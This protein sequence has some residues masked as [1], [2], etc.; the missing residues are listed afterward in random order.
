MAAESTGKAEACRPP[1]SDSPITGGET[2]DYW[3][4]YLTLFRHDC[5]ALGEKEQW[6]A[7][8]AGGFSTLDAVKVWSS[9]RGAV[10]R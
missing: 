5:H 1:A 2:P 10:P 3:G 8:R 7:G 6:G 9:A 4:H